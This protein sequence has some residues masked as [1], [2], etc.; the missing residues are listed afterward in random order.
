MAMAPAFGLTLLTDISPIALFLCSG[1]LSLLAIFTAKSCH[2][3]A[4]Q[5]ELPVPAIHSSIRNRLYESGQ[6]FRLCLLFCSER[7]MAVS[8]PL[9]R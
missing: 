4:E 3:H 6:E 8:I 2:T 5:A 9:L 1:G 7:L